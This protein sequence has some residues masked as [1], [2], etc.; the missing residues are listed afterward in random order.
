MGCR[1][2]SRGRAEEQCGTRRGWRTANGRQGAI[3]GTEV[4]GC[5]EEG[6]TY[7]IRGDGGVAE[8]LRY[9]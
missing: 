8:T 1:A 3:E 2:I 4:G 6:M 7:R 5:G 9:C